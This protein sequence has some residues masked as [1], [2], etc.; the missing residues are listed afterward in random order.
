MNEK[1][2]IFASRKTVGFS[3]FRLFG[4]SLLFC[5]L[6]NASLAQPSLGTMNISVVPL[7]CDQDCNIRFCI[8]FEL[9]EFTNGQCNVDVTFDNL[10]ICD[11]QEYS[12]I[13]AQHLNGT[14]EALPDGAASSYCFIGTQTQSSITFHVTVRDE[15][16]N[17]LILFESDILFKKNATLFGDNRISDLVANGI[18]PTAANAV[19]ARQ[20]IDIN[21]SLIIDED[22]IFNNSILR[23]GADAEIIVSSNVFFVINNSLIHTCDEKWNGIIVETNGFLGME[24]NTVN[25]AK[26]AVLAK[27]NSS[28]V[29][30][31]NKFLNNDIGIQLGES[32]NISGVNNINNILKGN[33]FSGAG[34]EIG[35]KLLGVDNLVKIESII[36]PSSAYYAAYTNLE[37]GI[38]ITGG[39]S[40]EV[41]DNIFEDMKEIGIDAKGGPEAMLRVSVTL[42][43]TNN[44]GQNTYKF[45]NV[46]NGIVCKNTLLSVFDYTFEDVKDNAIDIDDSGIRL[47]GYIVIEK[48][49]IFANKHGIKVILGPSRGEIRDNCIITEVSSTGIGIQMIGN[50]LVSNG[51]WQIKKNDINTFDGV[52]A[53]KLSN[54]KYMYVGQNNIDH[55]KTSPAI[56]VLGGE[57]NPIYCNYIDNAFLGI[58]YRGCPESDV[59]CNQITNSTNGIY[60]WFASDQTR[61]LGNML[62]GSQSDLR[63]RTNALT[64]TEKHAGNQFDAPSRKA[65]HD[66]PSSIIPSSKYFVNSGTMGSFLPQTVSASVQWFKDE[67]SSSSYFCEINNCTLPP[68]SLKSNN[69]GSRSFE[70]D[71]LE[72]AIK[73]N[74]LVFTSAANA[75]MNWTLKQHLY[76]RLSA[77]TA[78]PQSFSAFYNS[79]K[80]GSIGKLYDLRI[81]VENAQTLSS[82]E[83]TIVDNKLATVEQLRSNVNTLK[84]F[85]EVNG[86]PTLEIDQAVLPIYFN[87]SKQIGE[88][89]KVV[90]AINKTQQAAFDANIDNFIAQNGEVSFSDGAAA[91]NARLVNSMYFRY[92]KNDKLLHPFAI[93]QLGYI[94]YQCP[95]VGGDAVYAARAL[96]SRANLNYEYDDEPCVAATNEPIGGKQ[97]ANSTL[98]ANETLAYPNPAQ[99]LVNIH[100]NIDNLSFEATATLS[101]LT[102]RALIQE[103][104]ESYIRDFNLNTENLHSGMYLIH[105]KYQNGKSESLKINII[106]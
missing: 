67:S 70:D 6:T 56:S 94:A 93:E 21:G 26:T 15:D 81:A 19:T 89:L 31:I 71:E 59:E 92:L 53:L 34:E 103:N 64:R 85:K 40:V 13:D 88:E 100:R 36:T 41:S 96:L 10:D 60:Y 87:L 45:K 42:P 44:C 8:S 29:M 101:D 105:I 82:A 47:S 50:P 54:A 52:F 22:Y 74:S 39:G 73:N 51:G 99:E 9:A 98:N 30:F 38:E 37:K 102:G 95:S 66:G 24:R 48:N 91:T 35:I 43:P 33:S 90:G 63:Y 104:I 20:N 55:N 11:P 57:Y 58:D 65:A 16:V 75:G 68:W 1:I 3:A 32:A 79:H 28:A 49:L 72:L 62:H 97:M 61:T 84:L 23:M 18:L 77:A 17:G 46:K 83:Q 12:I 106:K 27:N 25:N 7:H 2:H 14:F 76:K 86:K 78:I 69:S 80:Q 5:L 4:F